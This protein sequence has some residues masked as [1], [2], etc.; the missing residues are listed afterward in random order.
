VLG[1]EL[2]DDDR[3]HQAQSN[4]ADRDEAEGGAEAVVVSASRLPGVDG[5]Q[6]L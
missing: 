4:K 3:L 1:D 5:V 2:A 6:T